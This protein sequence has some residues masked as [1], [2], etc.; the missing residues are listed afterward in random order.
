MLCHEWD[1]GYLIY[2][3]VVEGAEPVQVAAQ[4]GVSHATLVEQLRDAV[5]ELGVTYEDVAFASVGQS[6]QERVL[7]VLAGK[8]G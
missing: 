6:E 1:D 2:Q 3:L 8:R 7:A 5:D 4:R